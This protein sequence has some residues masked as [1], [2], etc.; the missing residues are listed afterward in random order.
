MCPLYDY[1]CDVCGKT[2]ER[3]L[4]INH[5]KP[6]CCSLPMRRLYSGGI[7][8]K[9][10]YPLWVNRMDD[11]HKAQ[12]QRGERLSFVHPSEILHNWD[13][14]KARQLWKNKH[15]RKTKANK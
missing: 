14:E 2:E 13:R 15:G 6:T 9:W 10:H 12:E 1:T 3:Y 4:P 7:L 11:I 5:D 8:I